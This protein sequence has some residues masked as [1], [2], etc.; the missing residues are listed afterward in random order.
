[1]RQSGVGESFWEVLAALELTTLVT[2]EGRRLWILWCCGAA[3]EQFLG[4]SGHGI[5]RN[6]PPR[7]GR[8]VKMIRV[9]FV[10][11]AHR[12]TEGVGLRGIFCACMMQTREVGS[13]KDFGKS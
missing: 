12:K 1:M 6:H 5:E 10:M 2:V 7:V 4:M 13:V 11:H 8:Y 9:S 3:L